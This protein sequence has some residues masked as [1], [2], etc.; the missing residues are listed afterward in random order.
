MNAGVNSVWI[1]LNQAGLVDGQ[2][3]GR[4]E[5]DS[6]WYIKVLLGF[7]GWFAALFLLGFIGVG[8]QFV[9]DSGVGTLITGIVT[10]SIAF[11]LLHKAK[12]EFF[13]HLALA[14]SLA[15]QVLIAAAMFDLMGRNDAAAWIM[16]GLIQAWLALIMPSFVH[17][18]F[19]S[20]AAAFALS[21]GM[22]HLGLPN[23]V[24][25]VVMFIAAWLWLNEF[26]Y[27]RNIRTIQA[28]AYGLVLALIQLKG[29]V[30][31]AHNN[32]S[33]VFG[34]R[35]TEIMIQPWFGELIIS[36]VLLYVVWSLLQKL[37]T[38]SSRIRAVVL[39]GTLLLCVVSMEAP[40]VSIGVTIILLGFAGSNRVL[41]GLGI[42]SLMFYVSSYYYL[43]ETTLLVKAQTLFVLGIVLLSTRW[44]VLRLTHVGKEVQ[45][46]N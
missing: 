42:I 40:G 32:L 16:I 13:E 45:D 25:G 1:T 11:L 22:S 44:L 6:P 24:T 2:A 39:L 8:F 26:R 15:G 7:S 28:I 10:V 9:L 37:G 29:T 30:L 27:M 5:L 33:W 19:S 23:I 35:R 20:Y 12:N 31:F 4:N 43:L 18:V 41:S 14:T 38:S 46:A 36:A 3:P 21:M 34:Q 17:R